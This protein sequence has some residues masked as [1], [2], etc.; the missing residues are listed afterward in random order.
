MGVLE[1]VE[2][3]DL[4]PDAVKQG[5]AQYT[6]AYAAATED[7]AKSEAEIGVEVYQ[8]M[9][10]AT[11]RGLMHLNGMLVSMRVHA[12]AC[13]LGAPA[14]AA[15]LAAVK[16]LYCSYRATAITL[17]CKSELR[18]ALFDLMF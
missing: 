12:S 17:T 8:A 4:D 5:L 14:T 18:P 9:S 3:D 6:A 13:T 10:Y 15:H 7:Y 1:A 16:R 11:T 2:L